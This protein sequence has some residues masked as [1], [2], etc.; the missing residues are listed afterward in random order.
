MSHPQNVS[1]CGHSY[2][3]PRVYRFWKWGRA[4]RSVPVLMAPEGAFMKSLCKT[5]K[6]QLPFSLP[7]TTEKGTDGTDPWGK[8]EGSWRGLRMVS[9]ED[10][11]VRWGAGITK[12]KITFQLHSLKVM[13][14]RSSVHY[15]AIC[16]K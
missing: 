5:D 15:T 2:C 16:I 11:E 9:K 6:D 4:I 1:R 3:F 13:T 7:R 14:E 8:C 12:H 10:T